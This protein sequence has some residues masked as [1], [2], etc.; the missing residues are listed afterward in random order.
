V[1]GNGRVQPFRKR[2]AQR[3]PNVALL[4]MGQ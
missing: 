4:T 2:I 1:A 3:R